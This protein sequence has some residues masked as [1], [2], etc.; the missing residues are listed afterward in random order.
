MPK[1][2][3]ANQTEQ[4]AGPWLGYADAAKHTGLSEQWLRELVMK[5]RIPF[6]KVGK[7]VLFSVPTLDEWISNGGP[8]AESAA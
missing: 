3:T 4:V 1:V 5:R 6:K 2:M 8:S 7:R